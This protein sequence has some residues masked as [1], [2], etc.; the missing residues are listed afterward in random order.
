MRTKFD[1]SPEEQALLPGQG[2]VD[3]YRA[4]G[5]YLSKQVFSRAELTELR[6]AA[7]HFYQHGPD[8]ALPHHPERLAYWRREHGEVHRHND[9]IAFENRVIG[10]A[11]SRPIIGAIAAQLAETEAIRLFQSTLISKPAIA[12]EPTNL[13]PW[14]FDK[15]YWATCS[16]SKMLTAFIPLQDCTV[17]NGTITMVDGSHL[18]QELPSSSNVHSHFAERDPAELED[19]LEKNAA[20]NS[21]RVNKVPVDIPAGHISFHHCRIYHGSG[22]NLS[23]SPRQAISLHLQPADNHW[24]A[25][26]DSA[27]KLQSY[28]HDTLVR[29]TSTGTPDYADPNYCP[30]IWATR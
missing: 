20:H 1:L 3:F 29:K 19:L 30:T 12:D 26:R 15:H 10:H 28:N 2:D 22:A 27:G 24:R 14:H 9:Y 25:F 7:E 23:A 18:W 5:W 6:A 16:S 21:A 11:L 8:Q 4:H 13:V 17:E